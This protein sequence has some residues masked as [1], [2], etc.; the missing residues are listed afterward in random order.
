MKMRR[1]TNVPLSAPPEPLPPKKWYEKIQYIVPIIV[2]VVSGLFVL[3]PRY[4]P[5]A[6]EVKK[7]TAEAKDFEL[8]LIDKKTLKPIDIRTPN[9][10]IKVYCQSPPLILPITLSSTKFTSKDI[11]TDR[12]VF[13]EFDNLPGYALVDRQQVLHPGKNEIYAFSFRKDAGTGEAGNNKTIEAPVKT[14]ILA[15]SV[16]DESGRPAE[17]VKISFAG[18]DTP[19][20]TDSQGHFKMSVNTSDTRIKVQA[21]KQG[22]KLWTDYVQ[23]NKMNIVIKLELHEE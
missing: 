16:L 2:A 10:K 21:I 6:D 18:N 3:I 1:V 23:V 15:G 19:V 5:P 14:S 8:L 11:S 7:A 4:F 12:P 22:Y 13:L 20:E 17:G 9:A